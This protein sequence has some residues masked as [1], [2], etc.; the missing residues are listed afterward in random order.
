MNMQ[1]LLTIQAQTSKYK[2]TLWWYV[3]T[4]KL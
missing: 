3:C 1:Q 2:C 4:R